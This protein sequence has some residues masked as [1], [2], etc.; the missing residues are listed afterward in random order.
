MCGVKVVSF[1]CLFVIVIVGT[2]ITGYEN[3]GYQ[4]CMFIDHTSRL[5]IICTFFHQ[6]LAQTAAMI[7]AIMRK[8]KYP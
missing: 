8:L 1:V 4:S 2:K 7:D 3:L 5:T 6:A